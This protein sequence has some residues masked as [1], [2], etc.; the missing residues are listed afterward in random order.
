[1]PLVYSELYQ[2]AQSRFR[3]ER[4]G[5][6]LQPTALVNETYLKLVDQKKIHWQSRTQFFGVAAMLMRRILID[7]VRS[8]KALKRPPSSLRISLSEDTPDSYRDNVDVLALDEALTK[9]QAV[10]PRQVRI[11]EMRFFVG[12]SNEEVAEAL[13]IS[14]AGVKRDWS[15]AKNWLRREL[16]PPEGSE[17]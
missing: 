8:R 9:L 3:Q 4:V 13:G 14:I 1:M 2:M 7:Y 10:A 17:R 6:T 5:D 16:S 11:V 12:M 15:A